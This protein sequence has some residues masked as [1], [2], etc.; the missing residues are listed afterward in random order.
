MTMLKRRE[1]I[2][3]DM[4]TLYQTLRQAR[5]AIGEANLPNDSEGIEFMRQARSVSA[6]LIRASH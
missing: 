4:V 3:D 2:P 1:L 6:W 5:N